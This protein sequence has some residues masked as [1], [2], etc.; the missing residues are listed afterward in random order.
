MRVVVLTILVLVL[1]V[2][3]AAA[4]GPDADALAARGLRVSWPLKGATATLWP[5]AT[6]TVKV[7][8]TRASARP[9]RVSLVRVTA[10]GIPMRTIAARRLRRGRFTVALPQGDG[11]HYEL[12][13]EAG[14]LRYRG[15]VRT[16]LMLPCPAKG[17]T[18]AELHLGT[19]GPVAPGA[20]VGYTIANTG[21]TCLSYALGY[22]WE[23]RADDGTWQVWPQE[24]YFITTI[25]GL[26]LGGRERGTVEV[27]P[28]AAPGRFRLVKE[29]RG[30]GR[31]GRR[32]TLT[33]EIDV[34]A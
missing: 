24:L 8:P 12:R 30:P 33:A 14:T 25:S 11:R 34:A 9:V 21:T 7:T 26:R 19:A 20:T 4:A 2:G 3:P 15:T 23:R 27:P 32:L 18:K 28:N 5:G 22:R 16:S 13:L 1:G 29:V 17:S 6:L 10:A 31:L